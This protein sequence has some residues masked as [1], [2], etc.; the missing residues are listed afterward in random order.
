MQPS[1]RS[2]RV[3][4]SSTF[5][6]MQAERDY[7]IKFI[8]PQLRKLCEQRGVTWNEVDLRWGITDEQSSEGKVLPICL[9]E[10]Q[11]CKP[12]FIALLGERYGWIPEE[13]SA[14]LIELEPW[15][16]NHQNQSVTE[17]EILH[18][19]LND[20]GMAEHSLFYFRYPEF[21]QKLDKE[22]Q[23]DYIEVPWK[24]DIEKYG[25]EEAKKRVE[26]R[27]NKL[28]ELKQRIRNS[29]L[30][31]ERK[32]PGCQTTGRLVIRRY[33]DDHRPAFP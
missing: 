14:E 9:A 3:F 2:I 21:I 5:R 31:L 28:E 15:L 7:L 33:E 1:E 18:G 24:S 22:Y 11:R 23:H 27:R 20:P 25:L 13:I 30:P 4:V 8:F 32:F 26:V 12:Y 6:D 19:V 16:K 10:I 29:R 17:L